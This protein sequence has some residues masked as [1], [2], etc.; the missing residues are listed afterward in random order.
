MRV[1]SPSAFSSLG[2]QCTLG[3]VLEKQFLPP[4]RLPLL[5]GKEKDWG[6]QHRLCPWTWVRLRVAG[7]ADAWMHLPGCLNGIA[8]C[9]VFR[10]DAF[11]PLWLPACLRVGLTKAGLRGRPP[12]LNLSS[13]TG[14]PGKCP[15]VL[16]P[17][18]LNGHI[19]E[20][21]VEIRLMVPTRRGSDGLQ[22]A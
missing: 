3:H 2:S 16:L 11:S 1:A 13:A 4:P 20:M 18:V 7:A 14:W 12:G 5:S 22:S 8:F 9:P 10:Q 6:K 19:C 17:P 15:H 21:G